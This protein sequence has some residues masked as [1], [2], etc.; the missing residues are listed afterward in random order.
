VLFVALPVMDGVDLGQEAATEPHQVVYLVDR[1]LPPVCVRI[2]AG[3]VRS[4]I[5][6]ASPAAAAAARFA[7]WSPASAAARDVPPACSTAA[8]LA[9]SSAPKTAIPMAPPNCAVAEARPELTP[10]FWAA[11][12][13]DMT[14]RA[15]IPASPVSEL[16]AYQEIPHR[17][18]AI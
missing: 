14:R 15:S 1:V 9:A 5:T 12:P 7:A 8:R 6:A 3:K 13:S 11:M 16:R 4:A 17:L 10:E 2:N 18:S